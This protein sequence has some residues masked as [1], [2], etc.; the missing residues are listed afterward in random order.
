[1]IYF[2]ICSNPFGTDAAHT[3]RTRGDFGTATKTKL[4]QLGA[5]KGWGEVGV[6]STAP[7]VRLLGFG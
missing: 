1:M 7:C 2:T 4:A 5:R 3:R 6:A